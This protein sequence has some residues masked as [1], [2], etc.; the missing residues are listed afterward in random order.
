[1]RYIKKNYRKTYS[2]LIISKVWKTLP[3]IV[4]LSSEKAHSLSIMKAT[5][6]F[7]EHCIETALDWWQLLC[8]R[9]DRS[10]IVLW[11]LFSSFPILRAHIL[12]F[13]FETSVSQLIIKKWKRTKLTAPDLSGIC[14]LKIYTLMSTH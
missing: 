6:S 8:S 13:G 10:Q 12:I 5:L 11:Q 9:Q 14:R 7:A 4:I 3:Y 2:E 1:M